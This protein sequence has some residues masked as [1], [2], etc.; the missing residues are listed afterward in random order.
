M[1]GGAA[2]GDGLA[3][4][5]FCQRTASLAVGDRVRLTGLAEPGTVLHGDDGVDSEAGEWL[6]GGR[7]GP[8]FSSELAV[9]WSQP[10]AE[11]MPAET[12]GHMQKETKSMA[13]SVERR[14][15][16]GD[17]RRPDL[18]ARTHSSSV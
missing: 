10:Q 7:T 1:S 11:K 14:I 6:P 3:D 5:R 16:L 13:G 18:Q 17:S 12:P 15:C 4:V 2:V 8:M 9:Y